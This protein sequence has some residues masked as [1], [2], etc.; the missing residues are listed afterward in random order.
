MALTAEST[1]QPEPLIETRD[2]H[3]AYHDR[4][5][6]LCGVNMALQTGE[7]LGLTG[8]NGG[9][10]ST[11][12]HMLVGLLRPHAGQVRAFGQAR[13][14]EGDFLEVRRR[15]GLVFQNADDQLFCPTVLEDVAFGPLNLGLSPQQARQTA[16][17]VLTRV[18]LAGF[19][20]RVT[21]K[22]SGGEKRLVAIA[23]VLAM[24]PD[25]LLLDE[26]TAGLDESARE[27]LYDVLRELPQAMLIVSHE[28]EVLTQLATRQA[29]LEQGELRAC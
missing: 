2:L 20:D 12:L 21:Y 13:V 7:T 17:D 27:R 19:E 16:A 25:V 29:T 14:R 1:T 6:V 26:P 9:G 3:F 24:S 23:T 10:K 5:E 18:G 22:L 11:L 15:V 8:P 28:P 4:P